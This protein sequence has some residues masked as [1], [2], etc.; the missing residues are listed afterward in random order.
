MTFS[1][2]NSDS[3]SFGEKT[4]DVSIDD[5]EKITISNKVDAGELTRKEMM[6]SI[7]HLFDRNYS[8]QTKSRK[9]LMKKYLTHE[10]FA[11]ELA[12]EAIVFLREED[13][14]FD[15]YTVVFLLSKTDKS[16]IQNGREIVRK[17]IMKVEGKPYFGPKMRKNI[18]KIKRKLN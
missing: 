4:K 15:Q 12:N 1:T 11:K 14:K 18:S 7:K 10:D 13:D 17:Y 16:S 9:V 6:K 2:C 8:I 5:F 3:S